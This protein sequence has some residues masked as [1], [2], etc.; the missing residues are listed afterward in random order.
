MEHKKIYNEINMLNIDD[1]VQNY[2][3]SLGKY[4]HTAI[5]RLGNKYGVVKAKNL[6][7]ADFSGYLNHEYDADGWVYMS[8]D[9]VYVKHDND[10]L[11]RQTEH[12]YSNMPF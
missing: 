11:Y 3:D 4:E 2:K 8:L 1:D 12:D 5:V 6:T 7:Y 10:N 9:D